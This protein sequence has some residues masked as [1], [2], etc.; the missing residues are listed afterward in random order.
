VVALDA[1]TSSD[2]V[3]GTGSVI[4][5]DL[6]PGVVALVPVD[7]ADCTA[8]LTQIGAQASEY[9]LPL[10]LI[11]APGQEEQLRGLA[12]ALTGHPSA[13]LIDP[14]STLR[15][16]YQTSGSGSDSL[17]L[18]LVRPDGRLYTVVND[19]PSGA[20]LESSLVQIGLPATSH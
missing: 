4:S 10:Y 15:R 3:G 12:D 16:T 9:R 6:R 8:R 18:L 11:G 7:C 5:T 14:S 19:P 20:R 13:V 2:V 1:G 17:L